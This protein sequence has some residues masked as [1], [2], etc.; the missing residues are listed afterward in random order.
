M[1]KCFKYIQL[2]AAKI[3]NNFETVSNIQM[4]MQTPDKADDT[5]AD[6]SEKIYIASI[7]IKLIISLSKNIH[8]C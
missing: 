7:A 5:G 2:A 1:P 6:P 3:I 8:N 4:K